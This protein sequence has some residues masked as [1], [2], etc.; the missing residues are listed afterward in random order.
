MEMQR[1]SPQKQAGVEV[2]RSKSLKGKWAKL[3]IIRRCV[4]MLICWREHRDKANR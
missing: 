1:S 2:T 3:Y 4:F